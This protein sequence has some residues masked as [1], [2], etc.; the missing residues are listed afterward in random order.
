MTRLQRN[1]LAC[2]PLP[3]E[4]VEAMYEEAWTDVAPLFIPVARI[5]RA[6]CVSHERLRVELIGCEVLL[7]E[8][9]YLGRRWSGEPNSARGNSFGLPETTR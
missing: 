8:A 5:C 4:E 6:L 2:L 7:T 9:G 1:A 3:A